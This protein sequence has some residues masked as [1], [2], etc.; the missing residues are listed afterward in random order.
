MNYPKSMTIAVHPQRSK[1]LSGLIIAQIM[2]GASNG[3]TLSMGSLLAA[4]LAGAAWGGSAAT[5]TTI[6]ACLLYTSRCV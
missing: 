1:V 6:G 5:F 2:V 4:H 3:V